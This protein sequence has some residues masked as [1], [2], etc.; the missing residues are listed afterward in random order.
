LRGELATA[1]LQANEEAARARAMEAATENLLRSAR[2][3]KGGPT[4]RPV[5]ED[6]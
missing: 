5:N 3:A 1:R 6:R 2:E 4:L